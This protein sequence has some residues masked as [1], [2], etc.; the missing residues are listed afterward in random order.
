MT[1][2]SLI[3]EKGNVGGAVKDAA[4]QGV[5]SKVEKINIIVQQEAVVIWH[6]APH[7]MHNNRAVNT[8]NRAFSGHFYT[9]PMNLIGPNI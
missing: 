7:S 9:V 6:N 1:T 2:F 5:R 8:P 3:K 4:V